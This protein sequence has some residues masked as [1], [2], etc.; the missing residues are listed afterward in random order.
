ML[1]MTPSTV[2]SVWGG[3]FEC[4]ITQRIDVQAQID[5]GAFK[6]AVTEHVPDS[7]DAD[8][9]PQQAHCECMAQGV[10]A[11]STRILTAFPEAF[12][13]DLVDTRVLE[14]PDRTAFP[15]EE[16]RMTCGVLPSIT[17]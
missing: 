6:I 2:R 8:A 13:E 5:A 15:Q 14:R 9:A 12:D 1:R 3:N 17:I 4:H 10:R 16:H 11:V 7:L